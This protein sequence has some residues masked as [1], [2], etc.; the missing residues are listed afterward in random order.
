[1]Q[2]LVASGDR[3][4]RIEA[5]LSGTISYIFNELSKG[6]KFS[7]L[8]IEAKAKGYTEPD[9]RDDLGAVDAARKT[10]IL[11]REA[12]FS[13]D[14]ND[15]KI[16]SLLP[17]Q[18]MQAPN[19]NEFLATLPE[20]DDF[21]RARVKAAASHNAVLRYVSTITP[22]SAALS[23]KEFDSSS[24]FWNL[25]GTENLVAFTTERY[26]QNPLVVRGPGAGAEVTAGGVFAEIL[27]LAE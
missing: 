12:G 17:A 2:D 4:L 21:Y 7:E 22:T 27:K 24:P 23:L 3:I 1:L 15:I 26:S 8:V 11:I 10:L 9:P 6:R 25:S 16:E 5:V 18:F 20:I 14:F 19:I 13:L